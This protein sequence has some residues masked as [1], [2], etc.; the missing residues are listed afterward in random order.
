ME[1][2]GVCLVSLGSVLPTAERS[3]GQLHYRI[4]FRVTLDVGF[5]NSWRNLKYGRDAGA[6]VRLWLQYPRSHSHPKYL[7]TTFLPPPTLASF[8]WLLF[9]TSPHAHIQNANFKM[10]VLYD[11]WAMCE[12]VA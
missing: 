5:S 9:Q 2:L 1:R 4:T 11:V 7:Y 12:C 8:H 10:G 3:R 6:L